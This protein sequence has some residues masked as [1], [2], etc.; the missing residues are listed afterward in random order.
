MDSGKKGKPQATTNTGH[1]NKRKPRTTASHWLD[2]SDAVVFQYHEER[3]LSLQ[4]KVRGNPRPL[5]RHRTKAR[6]VVYN[7]SSLLQ[8]SFRDQVLQIMASVGRNLKAPLFL[9]KDC[10]VMT[11]VLRMQR[12]KSHFVG[13]RRG[14][15]RLKASAPR[16]V[17]DSRTDVDNMAKFV[18]DAMNKVL[19]PDDHQI[20]S[21]RVTKVLDNDGLCEG[22]TEISIRAIGENGL[23]ALTKCT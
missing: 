7:P 12:P 3:L 19:Y 17:P 23:D 2:S 22:S 6:G 16:V 1:G 10:L 9:G 18:M 20:A 21:L 4:F 14:Q 13:S 8:K 11:V 15:D 5:I